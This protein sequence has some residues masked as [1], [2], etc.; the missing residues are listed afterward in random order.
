MPPL[1]TTIPLGDLR[2]RNQE[3]QDRRQSEKRNNPNAD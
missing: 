2:R 1:E 3:S